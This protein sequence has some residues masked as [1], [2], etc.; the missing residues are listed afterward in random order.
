[1]TGVGLTSRWVAANRAIET[2]TAT[3]LY[4]DPFARALAGAPGFEMLEAMRPVM[5]MSGFA[6]PHPYLTIRTRFFD[7][8]LLSAIRARGISQVVLLAAGMD[9][10]A[11]RLEWP[12]GV[13][14]F[15]IDRDDVCEHKEAVLSS[16]RATVACHRRVVRHDLGVAWGPALVDAG[17]E[18]ARASAF[19][20]E[21]LLYYLDEDQVVTLLETL[22]GL[23]APGSWLGVDMVSR[24]V[25]SSPSMAAYMAALARL[26]CPWR[27]SVSD[28]ERLLSAHGWRANYVLPGEPDADYGRWA[29]PVLPRSVSGVPRRYL[30]QAFRAD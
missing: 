21:G 7:D 22:G 1:M 5:G 11:F 9:T 16:L 12:R 6:G 15:E 10:R 14:V 17:F 4:R 8:A 27:S 18:P 23:A 30:V 26:G 19:L 2:E 13:R 29:A 20:A 24:E 3:P 28:P 25:L